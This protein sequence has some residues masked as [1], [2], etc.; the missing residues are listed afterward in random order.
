[1][2]KEDAMY[3]LAGG[4]KEPL[5]A[6]AGDMIWG[7]RMA[8]EQELLAGRL[9]APEFV[10]RGIGADAIAGGMMAGPDIRAV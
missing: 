1:M 8:A 10:L 7:D 9:P 4:L 2:S 5:E 6:I 3:T